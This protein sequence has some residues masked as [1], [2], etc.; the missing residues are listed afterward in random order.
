MRGCTFISPQSSR[1]PGRTRVVD[2]W[3][4]LNVFLASSCCAQ[5]E[6]RE[7]FRMAVSLLCLESGAARKEKGESAP[8][9][10]KGHTPGEGSLV[11]GPCGPLPPPTRA[12]N[13][14]CPLCSGEMGPAILG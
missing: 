12:V 10:G 2:R 5:V 1:P 9:S 3:A 8:G 4:G 7:T 13:P 14:H 11:G 6:F